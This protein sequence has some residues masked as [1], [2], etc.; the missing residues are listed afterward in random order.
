MAKRL[1]ICTTAVTRPELHTL[2]FPL[3]CKFLEGIKFTW[4]INI[5]QL[6]NQSTVFE[7][8]QN[9]LKIFSSCFLDYTDREFKFTYSTVGGTRESFYNSVQRLVFKAWNES[10]DENVLW[11]E[12]DWQWNEGYKLKQEDV[13][14]LTEMDYLQLVK[15]HDGN[16]VSFNPGIWGRE[17]FRRFCVERINL[18]YSPDNANPERRCT[19]PIE[20]VRPAVKTYIHKP[21]FEDIGR[22]WTAKNNMWRTFQKVPK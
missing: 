16:A 10:K 21:C 5:D 1:I 17:L 14:S 19:Y 8:H 9:L 20:V 15:R 13:D 3:Y 12:D 6:E 11:L 18:P 7:T 22:E 2:T 4:I